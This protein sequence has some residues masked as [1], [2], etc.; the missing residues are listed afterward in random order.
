[1]FLGRVRKFQAWF[2]KMTHWCES[3]DDSYLRAN[4][5]SLNEVSVFP[6]PLTVGSKLNLFSNQE[7]RYFWMNM[8][9]QHLSLGSVLR[10]TN[11]FEI[12]DLPGIYLLKVNRGGD[13]ATFKVVILD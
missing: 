2:A 10:G 4:K 6:N 3:N 12:P 5:L 9:G 8:Q 11:T 7:G 1:M 13:W